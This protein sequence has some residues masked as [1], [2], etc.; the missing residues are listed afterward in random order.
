CSIASA[1]ARRE[2]WLQTEI[3]LDVCQKRSHAGDEAPAE[4][5]AQLTQKLTDAGGAPIQID[6]Q[7]ATAHARIT[8][9]ELA[10]DEAFEP[11]TLH[12]PPG[13]HELVV[14][15]P[16]YRD[17]RKAI[18]VSGSAPRHVV[19][20]LEA[21]TTSAATAPSPSSRSKLVYVGG[22]VLAAGLVSWAW[23]GYE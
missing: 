13:H 20:T 21:T 9:A 14:T 22:G 16:G 1:Y 11:R 2:L 7:P 8:M 15:A 17:A 5:V 23:M 3:W 18:D 6:V 12:L 10:P 4:L 19:I